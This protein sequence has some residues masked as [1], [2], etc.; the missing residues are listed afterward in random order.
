MGKIVW[1]DRGFSLIEMMVAVVIMAIGLLALSTVMLQAI[2]INLGNE[3]RSTAVR[4]CHQTA[5]MLLALPRENV[6]SC[7]FTP[8]KNALNYNPAYAYDDANTCIGTSGAYKQYPDPVHSIKG[9]QQ[10]FNIV[11][12]VTELSKDLTQV[13]ISVAYRHRGEDFVN[14]AVVY[15]HRSK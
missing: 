9:F 5:E 14:T 12:T 7:G 11:W 2:T 8:D 10:P 15:K 3:L 1:N 4:L 6:S 13:S